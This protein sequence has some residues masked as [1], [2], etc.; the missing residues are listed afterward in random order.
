VRSWYNRLLQADIIRAGGG[1]ADSAGGY[2]Y[3]YEQEGDYDEYEMLGEELEQL[4]A[5]F[6]DGGLRLLE[7]LGGGASTLA[8]LL[9]RTTQSAVSGVL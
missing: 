3:D 2:E 9:Q 5:L 1:S 6:L 4:P 8:P 7:L